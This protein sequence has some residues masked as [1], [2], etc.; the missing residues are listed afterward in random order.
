MTPTL[1][2]TLFRDGEV[3]LGN[4][5]RFANLYCVDNPEELGP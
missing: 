5:G 1:A 2:M 4:N 3:S